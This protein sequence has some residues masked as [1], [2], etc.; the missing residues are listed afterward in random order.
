MGYIE[1]TYYDGSKVYVFPEK[2][3]YFMNGSGSDRERT[4]IEFDN[5]VRL[6]VNET[7]EQ[8]LQKI[9]ELKK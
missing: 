1:L 8:V 9:K 5:E 6:W 4:F 3:L 2:I 7:P